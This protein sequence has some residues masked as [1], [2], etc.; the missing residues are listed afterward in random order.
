MTSTLATVFDLSEVFSTLR[1][2]SAP[3]LRVKLPPQLRMRWGR[4]AIW[5]CLGR[6]LLSVN[7]LGVSLLLLTACQQFP[8]GP[9]RKI[10]LQ[11][12]WELNS[13]DFIAGYLITGGL[14]DITVNIEN[15]KLRAPFAG[16]VELAAQGAQCIYFSTPEIPAYLFRYCGVRHPHIGPIKPGEMMGRGQHIHFATLRRQPDGT[17]AMV[18]PSNHVLEKTLQ[19]SVRPSFF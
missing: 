3:W 2:T 13:G 11:Q 12:S 17:W 18:E 7:L 4:W 16:E 10:V 5:R 14:G 9:A 19:S 6:R 1:Q 8:S 15:A